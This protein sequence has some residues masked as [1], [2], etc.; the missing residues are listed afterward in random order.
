MVS[1]FIVYNFSEKCYIKT[2]SDHPMF[3]RLLVHP[4][5]PKHVPS[6]ISVHVYI[7]ILI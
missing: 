6:N 3:K 7:D 2:L 4:P 5:F 1:E